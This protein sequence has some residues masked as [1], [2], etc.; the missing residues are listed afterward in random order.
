[1]SGHRA[2]CIAA[3]VVVTAAALSGCASKQQIATNMETIVRPPVAKEMAE[4]AAHVTKADLAECKRL[5]EEP[6]ALGAKLTLMGP[7]RPNAQS[8]CV[9]THTIFRDRSKKIAAYTARVRTEGI[10]VFSGAKIFGCTMVLENGKV[11]V[12][13]GAPFKAPVG[14]ICHLMRP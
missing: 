2:F 8:T 1:M 5:V 12:Q 4:V 11:T 14:S 6:N 10:A 13:R 3:A 7:L 9:S